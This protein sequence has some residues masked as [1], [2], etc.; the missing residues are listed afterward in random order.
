MLREGYKYGKGLARSIASD[1]GGDAALAVVNEGL[2][3]VDTIGAPLGV[4]NDT[5]NRY[6]D[7]TSK[8]VGKLQKNK[9]VTD[10]VNS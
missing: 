2:A 7:L 1:I 9:Y 3:G 4:L 8:A 6:T 5:A 10:F